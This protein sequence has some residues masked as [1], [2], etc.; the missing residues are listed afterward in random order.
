MK[1]KFFNWLLVRV[2]HK[3]CAI[4]H[5]MKHGLKAYVHAR[6]DYMRDHAQHLSD[7]SPYT[8]FAHGQ[9]GGFGCDF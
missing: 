6:N 5:G 4:A 9:S 8:A 7:G 3:P 1:R 2:I